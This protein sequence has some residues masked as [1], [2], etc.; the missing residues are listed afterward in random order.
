VK[1]SRVKTS[2]L[3]LGLEEETNQVL[4]VMTYD[5]DEARQ[6]LAEAGYPDGK[7]FPKFN[8]LINQ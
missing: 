2:N 8:I 3:Q 1:I 4:K 7:G 5:P 6:L